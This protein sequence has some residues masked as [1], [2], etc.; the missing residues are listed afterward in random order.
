MIDLRKRGRER[1]S[2][3]QGERERGREIDLLFYFFMRS[4][5]DSFVCPDQRWNRQPGRVRTTLQVL[6][7]LAR[8]QWPYLFL[9]FSFFISLSEL[10]ELQ[11]W[12]YEVSGIIL[13]VLSCH[14]E[15]FRNILLLY[16]YFFNFIY[17]LIALN[18][19]G[20]IF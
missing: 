5:A 13:K 17:S 9:L 10:S 1:E 8:A 14:R 4:L 19:L 11:V 12:L 15:N 16:I 20:H 6:D 2:R 7:C 18:F 3:W